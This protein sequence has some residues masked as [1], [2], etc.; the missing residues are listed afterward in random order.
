MD[1]KYAIAI[2]CIDGRIQEPVI[3][4]IKKDC[5]A[6]YVDLI[7]NDG[8]VN[9]VAGPVYGPQFRKMVQLIQSS[10]K[11]K[12]SNT[13]YIT[14]HHDCSGNPVSDDKQKEQLQLSKT[15]LKLHLTIDISI[16]ALWV[17]ENFEVFEIS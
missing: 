3:N 8:I 6:D 11:N 7:T 16:K 17:D 4:Y 5:G 10:R 14:A 9:I 15:A 13:I 1:K 2:N 12:K